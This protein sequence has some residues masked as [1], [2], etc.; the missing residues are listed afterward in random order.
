MSAGQ[1]KPKSEKWKSAQTKN[2]SE[3]QM[4][5]AK[6]VVGRGRM[7]KVTAAERKAATDF[8]NIGTTKWMTSAE[9][10]GKGRGGLLVDAS[11]K[12]VT[13]TVKLPSG[14]SAT[15]VRGKRVG[16]ARKSATPSSPRTQTVTPP[17]P[18]KPARTVSAA[19][20]ANK[21]GR[22]TADRRKGAVAAPTQ[23]TMSARAAAERSRAAARRRALAKRKPRTTTTRATAEDYY[24]G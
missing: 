9:R 14:Q 16:V 11:G 24:Y 20:A 1:S 2:L 13:G 18:S 12:A 21:S 8:V 3:S 19:A 15:Y 4:K 6:R 7:E 23:T 17:A 5:Q 22:A 10:G